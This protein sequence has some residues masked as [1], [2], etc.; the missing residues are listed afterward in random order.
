MFSNDT[1]QLQ[2]FFAFFSNSV[3]AP[4]QIMVTIILIY[5]QMKEATFVGVGYMIVLLPANGILFGNV[6]IHQNKNTCH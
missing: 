6:V 1:K 4:L 2:N 3:V 5:F